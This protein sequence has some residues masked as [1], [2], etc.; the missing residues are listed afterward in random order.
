MRKGGPYWSL[1]FEVSE[2]KKF[3]VVDYS[4]N[5]EFGKH[6]MPDIVAKCIEGASN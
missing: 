2:S 1:M 4:E 3:K 5:T 6:P